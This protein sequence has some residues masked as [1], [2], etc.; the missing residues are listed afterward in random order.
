MWLVRSDPNGH[1]V[2]NPHKRGQTTGVTMTLLKV[3]KWCFH[4]CSECQG[5]LSKWWKVTQ[6]AARSLVFRRSWRM[7]CPPISPTPTKEKSQQGATVRIE[8]VSGR[9]RLRRRRR[10]SR[11]RRPPI[12]T[13][14]RVT[15]VSRWAPLQRFKQASL[16]IWD[17]LKRRHQEG[18]RAVL[19]VRRERHAADA[20][21]RGL[22]DHAVLVPDSI[23]FAPWLVLP[24]WGE[25]CDSCQH[26]KPPFEG[27]HARVTSTSNW[28]QVWTRLQ[29]AVGGKVEGV[30]AVVFCLFWPVPYQKSPWTTIQDTV[31]PVIDDDGRRKRGAPCGHF[32]GVVTASERNDCKCIVNFNELVKIPSSAGVDGALEQNCGCMLLLTQGSVLNGTFDRADATAQVDVPIAPRKLCDLSFGTVSRTAW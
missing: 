20:L 1:V 10:P 12:R 22:A 5:E 18:Q 11:W 2:R 29:C 19:L 16:S 30:F 23:G 27:R 28:W 26:K 3:V 13:P 21:Q 9:V 6:A 31:K 8:T 24:D 4:V 7:K 32:T 17:L 25:F 14:A 15:S